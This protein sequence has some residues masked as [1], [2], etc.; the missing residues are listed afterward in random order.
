MAELDLT[1]GELDLRLY[2]CDAATVHVSLT[3]D[4]AV[5]DAVLGES[6]MQMPAISSHKG[7]I[8]ELK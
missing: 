8:G 4:D 3:D 7:Q 6:T 5:H 1:P 2:Q